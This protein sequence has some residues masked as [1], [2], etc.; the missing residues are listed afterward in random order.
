LAKT[1]PLDAACLAH[2]AEAIRPQPRPLPDAGTQALAALLARHQFLQMRIAEQQRLSTATGV[3]RRDIQ[4]H[5]D[6]L[7][8]HLDKMSRR[9]FTRRCG[10]ARCGGSKTICCNRYRGSGRRCRGCC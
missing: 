8:R 9:T 5:L 10:R 1:D 2:F 6:F 3:I 7:A 4:Q